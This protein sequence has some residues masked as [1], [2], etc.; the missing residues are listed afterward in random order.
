MGVTVLPEHEVTD[1]IPLGE[2]GEQ[3]YNITSGN[4]RNISHH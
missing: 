3:G 4:P 1:V 2:Q